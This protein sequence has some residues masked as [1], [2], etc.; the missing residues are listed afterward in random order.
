MSFISWLRS[1]KS[2][3]ARSAS[4]RSRHRPACRLG[5]ERL[6]DRTLLN[7]GA[8]DP[9]FGVGGKVTTDFG[10]RSPTSDSAQAVQADGKIV[11]AGSTNQSGTRQDFAV[12]RYNADGSLDTSFGSGGKVTIDFGSPGDYRDDYATGVAVDG[13]GRIVLAGQTYNSQ[14][15]TGLDFAAARLNA[16]G[17]LDTSFDSDGKQTI[18]FGSPG[19]YQYDNATGVAVDGQ[20]CIVLAGNTSQ[21]GTGYD[22]AA[23]RL[24]TDGSLDTSFDGDGKVTTDIGYPSDDFTGYGQPMALQ[25]DGKIVVAGS[26]Y[27]PG[28]GQ[29]FFVARY[30]SDGSLDT[31][32]G[33]GGK[34][35]IDFGSPGQYQPDYATGVAVDG[36]G[37]IV[38]AGSTYNY[39]SGTSYDFAAAR[40]NANGSLDTSFDGDGKQTVDFGSPGDY[41]DNY[42]AGVAVDGQ[43]RIVLAGSTDN[44]QSGTSYDFAAARLNAD[45]SLDTSFDGDGKQTIDFG[46]P[47]Q[48]QYDNATGVAVDGQGCI[49]LA[50]QTYNY[51]SGTGWDF[52]AARLNANGSLDTSFD[53]DGKQTVDFGSP[54]DYR[55]DYAPGVAVDGQGRIV[56][57]GQTYNYQS[58]TSYDFAAARLNTDGSLD[59][60]FDGDGKVTTDFGSFN[61]GAAGVVVQ[62]DGKVLAVGWSFQPGTNYDFALA[63]YLGT[64]N[65]AP[66]TFNSSVTTAEDSPVSGILPAT[67][68]ENDPLTYSLVSGPQAGQL[69]LHADGSFTYTPGADFNGGDSFT[70]KASDG[71][72][73]SNLATVS[74]TVHPVNDAPAAFDGSVTTA[75]DTSVSGTL[76]ATDAENDPL[77][78]SLVSG[79]QAGQLT[80]HAD[81]SFTYTPGANYNGGDSFTFK[82]SD[83]QAD[84]N[85]ATVSIT[86]LPVND[87]PAAFD[88]SVTTAEDSPV[89]GILPATDAENDPL[90]YSL[91]SGPHAGQLTLHADGSFTYTPGADY[92]GGDSFTFKASD[93][94]ADSNVATVSI[95]VLPVN[96]APTA[97]AQTV[98]VTEDGTV[99]ITLAG[100]D[101]EPPAAGLT[102]TITTVPA[103]GVLLAADGHTVTAG[104]SFQGPP[105]LTYVPGAAIDGARTVTFTFTVTDTGDGSAPP[106]TSDPATVTIN[107]TR[108]VADGAVTVQGGILRIGGTSGNDNIVVTQTGGNLVVTSYAANGTTVLQQTTVAA[109]GV[110]EIRAWGRG[111]DDRIDLS[112]VAIAAFLSGGDGNDT[113]TGGSADDLLLGGAGNDAL[114]GGAGNDLLVGGAGSDRIVGSAGNDVLVAGEVAATLTRADLHRALAAWVADKTYDGGSEDVLDEALITDTS[115]DQLT[116]SS[117]ADL[118][119]IS[120]GDKVTDLKFK[121]TDGDWVVYV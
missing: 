75:E 7:A 39:Q 40:L 50:G 89:S 15:G 103:D 94:Q 10:F 53:G 47:G 18:D 76:S 49:V 38:L 34:V 61:D 98:S 82:A 32:F 119:F 106:R 71:Q 31:S 118:F 96:D 72:A 90:T 83:G 1:R 2:G 114:T 78:Y 84:S 116:G 59:T 73:D 95:N 27:Q 86:V 97:Q 80:L 26:A 17:S 29:D 100:T 102:F 41:R 30:N 16:Y 121:N 88:G 11:V 55:D 64:S 36:Q 115:I 14:S 79:P 60:S 6:E 25:A 70:F 65:T 56:L 57:A 67:D 54:G 92:N 43:G 8:L 85:L 63:R 51:Q 69:T 28:T 35:T 117:G 23:A 99:G 91:V 33:S 108:A 37:R 104:E 112:N 46:S 77:T 45:G 74:I 62:P 110:S 5:V 101:V 58:G 113:L 105:A 107:V 3:R 42:A 81:G 24:N 48:Y 21:S 111:G 66:T 44:Y 20:G 109:A 9:T 4:G 13:Q 68:A 52:A 19:Q 87:A 22:F 12:V 93:G 120:L